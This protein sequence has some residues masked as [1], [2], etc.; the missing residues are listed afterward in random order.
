MKTEWKLKWSMA[1]N[2]KCD[3]MA[4]SFCEIAINF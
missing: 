2:F 1:L 4:A 3:L